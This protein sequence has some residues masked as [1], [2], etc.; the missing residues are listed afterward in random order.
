ML[1]RTAGGAVRRLPTATARSGVR[2]TDRG[3][4]GVAGM[5]LSALMPVSPARVLTAGGRIISHVLT[6]RRR[7]TGGVLAGSAVPGL[8]TMRG[9]VARAMTGARL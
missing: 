3:T 7:T 2:T 9:R 1:L 5:T 4:L 8:T 6:P